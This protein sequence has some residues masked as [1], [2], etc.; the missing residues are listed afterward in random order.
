MGNRIGDADF[1]GF[2]PFREDPRPI[3]FAVM[4]PKAKQL[5]KMNS[6]ISTS[7]LSRHYGNVEAVRELSKKVPRGSLYRLLGPNGAGK[8]TTI[9]VTFNLQS[10]A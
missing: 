8:T 2:A 5:P 1:H 7:H 9:Q 3:V 6:A 10:I 4:F